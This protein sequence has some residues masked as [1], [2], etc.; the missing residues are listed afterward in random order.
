MYK[1]LSISIVTLLMA[2]ASMT[3]A[4]DANEKSAKLETNAEKRTPANTI[5]FNAELQVPLQAL[6]HLGQMIE[7]ARQ[8]ADPICI[9]SAANILAAAESLAG[10]KRAKLTSSELWDEA[11]KL[12]EMRN[13]SAEL[14]TLASLAG[15]DK[16]TSLK[17]MSES[18]KADEDAAREAEEAGETAKD[19]NGDLHIYNR[20]HEYVSIYI[21][22]RYLRGLAPHSSMEVHLHHAHVLEAR[23]HY[24]RW[25]EHIEGDRHH[26][27]WVIRDPHH[28]H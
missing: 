8:E 6:S 24:H 12:A 15:D 2:S 14:L 18:A 25:H 11:M 16:A 13:S 27:D 19:L 26:Y 7:E 22:G 17:E 3:S 5:D 1:F 10:D 28:P 23:S 20:S 4:Q 21:D 9:A